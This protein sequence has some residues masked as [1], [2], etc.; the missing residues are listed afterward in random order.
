MS[1]RGNLIIL[2]APSGSGKTSLAERVVPGLGNIRFSISHTTR[3]RREGERHGHEYFF[4]TVS[5]FKEMID[6]D[7]FLEWA[8]VYG[9]FY[10]TSRQFVESQLESG[11]DVLL[12]VDIQGAFRVSEQKPEA[13]LVFVMPPSYSELEERL[14][15]RGLD[16]DEV[17][18]TRLKIARDEIKSYKKYDYVIINRDLDQSVLELKAVIMA[19][20]CRLGSRFQEAEPIVSTFMEEQNQTSR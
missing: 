3:K 2:S 14:R 16:N 13:V 18:R 17:I 19:S 9:N 12:D 4:V 8:E 7:K 10:G 6:K 20:R 11:C 1:N 15:G 5:E